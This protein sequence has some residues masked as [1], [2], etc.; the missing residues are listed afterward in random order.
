MAQVKSNNYKRT[1]KRHY[2]KHKILILLVRVW[3]LLILLS[4]WLVISEYFGTVSSVDFRRYLVPL[5]NPRWF[6][7]FHHI[8]VF[9][10]PCCFIFCFTFLLLFEIGR[11]GLSDRESPFFVLI[12][13]FLWLLTWINIMLL[14]TYIWFYFPS[15]SL[16]GIH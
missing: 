14:N 13:G 9:C 1:R 11:K 7:A 6:E 16:L 5:L 4:K 10:C 3:I 12:I 2:V 15:D 8:V